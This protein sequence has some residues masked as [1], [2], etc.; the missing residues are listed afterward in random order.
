MK[1]IFKYFKI[2]IGLFFSYPCPICKNGFSESKN[3][4]CNDCLNELHLVQNPICSCCGSNLDGIL[5]ICSKCVD[6]SD[7]PWEN[8]VS[9][10]NMEGSGQRLIYAL[11][12]AKRPEIARAIAKLAVDYIK[13]HN[14]K[15]DYLVP[16]SLHWTRLLKRGFNQSEVISKVISEHLNIP[17]YNVLK[18]SKNT[19]QQAKL[20]R[21]NRIKNLIGAFSLKKGAISQNCNILL[22]D[23]VMTTGST[24]IEAGKALSKLNCNN[25]NI[26]T[27]ARK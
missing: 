5:D 1:L 10:Y 26:F 15:L 11:K 6:F 20:G 25:I 21:E 23:D 17:V 8:G 9:L 16:V 2:V 18:R 4:I 14:L 19:G 12:Y 22:V 27:I 3:E 7:F 24:L 13:K